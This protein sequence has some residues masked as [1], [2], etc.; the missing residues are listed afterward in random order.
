MPSGLRK[1][2]IPSL[3]LDYPPRLL[4]VLHTVKALELLIHDDDEIIGSSPI[5]LITLQP[6]QRVHVVEPTTKSIGARPTIPAI[7]VWAGVEVQSTKEFSF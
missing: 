3:P 1:T 4:R 5:L 6:E 7:I 2:S